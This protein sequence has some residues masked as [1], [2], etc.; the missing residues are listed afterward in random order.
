MKV[1]MKTFSEQLE[2]TRERVEDTSR[3]F[4]LLDSCQDILVDDNKERDDF[5][6]LAY[7]SGNERLIQICK[8][9]FFY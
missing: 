8:V 1:Q 7:R 4:L 6:R 3:C 9:S 2:E 5:K